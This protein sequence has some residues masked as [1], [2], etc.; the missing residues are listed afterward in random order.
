LILH[1]G[2]PFPGG[3]LSVDQR[4]KA[5]EQAVNLTLTLLSKE[6]IGP[7]RVTG[8]LNRFYE[9]I[10]NT[11]LGDISRQDDRQDDRKDDV[12]ASAVNCESI[13]NEEVK[14]GLSSFEKDTPLQPPSGIRG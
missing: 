11:I 3:D 13:K 9:S 4:L 8:L 10:C 5:M 12:E 14:N 6:N 1:E 2:K 7:K